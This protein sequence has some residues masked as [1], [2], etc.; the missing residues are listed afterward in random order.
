MIVQFR[1]QFRDGGGKVLK[2][3]LAPQVPAKNT[4]VMIGGKYYMIGTSVWDPDELTTD[5]EQTGEEEILVY[6]E[7]SYFKQG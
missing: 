3:L 6:V 4:F 1:L 5:V 2:T 7:V